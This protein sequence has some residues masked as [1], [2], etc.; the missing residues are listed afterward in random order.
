VPSA[1]LRH[2]T[3]A[4]VGRAIIAVWQQDFGV[5]S[6]GRGIGNTGQLRGTNTHTHTHTHRNWNWKVLGRT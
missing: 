4:A 6:G 5:S 3:T 1:C 2:M